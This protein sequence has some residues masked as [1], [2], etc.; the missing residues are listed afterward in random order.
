MLTLS[1]VVGLDHEKCVNCH[2]CISACPVKYCN[3]ASS[4]DHVSI[5]H[6]MC[7]GCGH[8]IEICTHDARYYMDDLEAM[9]QGLKSSVKMIA[10]VAPSIAASFKQKDY[11]RLNGFLKEMGIE[12]VFDVSFGAELT[13]KSYLE[14][15]KEENPSTFIAQPCPAVVSYIQL[16]KPELLDYLIPIDSPMAHTMKF[17][18]EFYP[19][20]SSHKIVAISPCIAKKREFEEV[21]LGDFNVTFKSINGYLQDLGV[22]LETY[23]Q[24]PYDGPSAER[25]ASFST[26]GGL[27]MT[28]MREY[29][30]IVQK[31]RKIEGIENICEYFHDLEKEI[32]KGTAPLMV[33]CLSCKNGCNT[34]PGTLTG[35]DTLDEI[36]HCIESRKKELVQAYEETDNQ[37]LRSTIDDHWDRNRYQRKYISLHDNVSIEE[38][39]QAEIFA[40]YRLLLKEK[41]EDFLNCKSCG[42]NSC[43]GMAI[44][45]Y[46]K[47]N[48]I[49]NCFLYKHKEL[50]KSIRNYERANKE[51]QDFAYIASHDLREPLRKITAFGELLKDSLGDNLE[52]DDLEN[53][54]YM[55]D[56]AH[57]LQEMINALLTYSRISTRGSQFKEVDLNQ[58]LKEIIKFELAMQIEETGGMIKVPESIPLVH[59][60]QTQIR[61]LLQNLISNA[62]KYKRKDVV[63]EI[64]VECNVDV[65][66]FVT[67]EIQDN[68]IGIRPEYYERVFDMF[69]RVHTQGSYEGCGIGLSVCKKIIERHGG[70]IGLKENPTGGTIFWFTLKPSQ[71]QNKEQTEAKELLVS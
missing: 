3:D 47:L 57:R 50:T 28:A 35:G 20:Y 21:G 42:Y 30:E 9:I 55:V 40:I 51:L 19:Q 17:I 38:P 59:G 68:G 71:K 1:P 27:T 49:E 13:V 64:H 69:R 10:I 6:D 15:L 39:S 37:D 16:Y 45:I 66:N 32:P 67:V 23:S 53:L 41:E 33:D 22:H 62:L 31:T 24:V 14:Y 25:A 48:V 56:G 58:V 7:I 54:D 44:A 8:C 26:P 18:R 43:E 52:P 29:E 2:T 34:G 65:E 12:A 4:S 36:E 60:D 11:L 5:N 46:N 61:Q 63:P 70:Q